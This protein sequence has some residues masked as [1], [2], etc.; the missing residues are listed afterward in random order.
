MVPGKTL[1]QTLSIR[2]GQDDVFDY[3]KIGIVLR[4]LCQSDPNDN[5]PEIADTTYVSAYFVPGCSDIKLSSPGQ[6]WV[7][8]TNTP[9]QD[10]LMVRID[11]YNLNV[12]NFKRIQFQY[13]PA[14][15][16]DFFTDMTFYNQQKVT[17]QEFDAAPEPKMF[18][19]TAAILYPFDMTSLPD[20]QYDI[21]VVA[22]CDD[23][24]ARQ[25]TAAPT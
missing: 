1:Q 21:R 5:L 24:P 7:V 15:S 16:S 11:G 13:R 6:N 4:S 10:T 9:Q 20:Q 8:N 22:L 3:E 25:A 17:Q 23:L 14:G 2:Q 18:V 12:D 19:N